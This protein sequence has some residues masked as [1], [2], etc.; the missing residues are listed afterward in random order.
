MTEQVHRMPIGVA[1]EI[2]RQ[3]EIRLG[4]LLTTAIAADLRAIT[5]A[6]LIGATATVVAAATLAHW[7][8]AEPRRSLLWAGGVVAMLLFTAMALAIWTGRA[9]NFRFPGGNPDSLREWAWDSD[10]GSWRDEAQLLDAAGG[11]YE[12][13]INRN[14]WFL[15]M[16]GRVFNA[17]I[18]TSIAALPVG[19][20]TFLLAS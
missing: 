7:T 11:R 4:A 8:S 1:R 15:I 2:A 12:E 13:S 18:C 9:S 5:F 19:L 16:N 17:A 3:G 10:A 20:V 6:G 14:A